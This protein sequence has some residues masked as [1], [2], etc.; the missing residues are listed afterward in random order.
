[1][2]AYAVVET[3]GKQYLVKVNDRLKIEK[4]EV[5][6]GKPVELTEVLAIS[7]GTKL[8]IGK[9]MVKGA[10]VLTTCLEQTKGPKVR[11]FKKRRRKGYSKRIGH[12]QLLT[13]LKV[14]GI[15]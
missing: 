10:K 12:R 9:P 3:G 1:M 13:V 6:A 14:D 11:S 2:E 15:Q 7:D 5:E 8:T 4:L